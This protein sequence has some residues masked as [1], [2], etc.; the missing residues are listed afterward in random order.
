MV[1]Q[2]KGVFK[3]RVFLLIL[4]LLALVFSPVYGKGEPL[5][6]RNYSDQ[7][8]DLRENNQK[9]YLTRAYKGD[10]GA[11]HNL[12]LLMLDGA[13]Q[14]RVMARKWIKDSAIQEYA[15]ALH[16]MGLLIVQSR[17]PGL[18]LEDGRM[19]L[20][21]SA[22]SGYRPA[23]L[24]LAQSLL[25]QTPVKKHLAMEWLRKGARMKD[26]RC[27]ALLGKLYEE[28]G[29]SNKQYAKSYFWYTLAWFHHN[30]RVKPAIHRL[31]KLLSEQD[32][33]EI[34]FLLEAHYQVPLEVIEHQ[35]GRI[36][37]IS[38]RT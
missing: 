37:P 5:K 35:N 32:R 7:L 38:L 23:H 27:M 15:P 28:Y 6:I 13:L 34:S 1:F 19:N 14:N 9:L 21:K 2:V 24:A 25:T 10:P 16:T 3:R 8:K 20:A 30:H 26:N 4:S 33:I 22:T 11:Q 29:T 12:G 31:E 36:F 17:W 18:S